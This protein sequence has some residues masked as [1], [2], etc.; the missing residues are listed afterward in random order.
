[1]VKTKKTGGGQSPENEPQT[2]KTKK[3][4]KVVALRPSEALTAA[5][6]AVAAIR[7]DRTRH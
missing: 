5:L 6:D 3:S 1:M 4:A 7:P 2:A